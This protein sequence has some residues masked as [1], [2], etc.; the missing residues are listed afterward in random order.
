M[1]TMASA[2]A[3]NVARIVARGR[4]HRRS[5]LL[6]R[7]VAGLL[8]LPSGGPGLSGRPGYI[9]CRRATRVRTQVPSVR[10]VWGTAVGVLDRHILML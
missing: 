7:P 3:R 5:Y 8:L 10:R 9:G 2:V 6:R 4:Q 1:A